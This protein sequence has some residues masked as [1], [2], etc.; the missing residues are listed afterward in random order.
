M[1][2]FGRFI[3]EAKATYCG[4]CGTRHVPP[5]K[6]G[7]CPALKEEVDYDRHFSRQSQAVQTKIN[8]HLRQGADYPT[9]ARKAGATAIRV[10]KLKE[11]HVPTADEPT[12]HDKKMAQKVRDLL[13]KEK[14]PKK[15]IQ[16]DSRTPQEKVDHAIRNHRYDLM[17]TTSPA[18]RM[19]MKADH[20]DFLKAMKKKH[21]E[22]RIQEETEL[23]ESNNTPYVRPHIEKGSTEQSGW[24]AS[25]KHGKVKYFG[26]AFK[27]SAEK[28]A[29]ISEETGGWISNNSKWKQAI[30]SAHGEDV[31]FK[32]KSQPG[33]SG[34][35]DTHATNA[36]GTVVGV[37]QHHNKMGRVYSPTNE[38]TE[39][40]NAGTRNEF[41]KQKIMH[42]G[43][44]VATIHTYRGRAG[45]WASSAHTPDGKDAS[46]KYGIGLM[47]TKKE[48]ISKIKNYHKGN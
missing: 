10:G 24:K 48:M 20:E 2:T 21:P 9:A 42:K 36:S 13:A 37:Y 6:G 32:T 19:E 16:E 39:I 26:M 22:V 33:V 3:E 35:R 14:K 29:G 4:R 23:D 31:S 34:K 17:R 5:S 18:E 25:N 15:A 47:D 46:K 40:E 45:G 38:E 11:G 8:H 28:H 41:R 1:K 7:T 27:K 12:E 30:K 43:E 44:H